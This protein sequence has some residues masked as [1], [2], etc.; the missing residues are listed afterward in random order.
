M[1][2]IILKKIKELKIPLIDIDEEKEKEKGTRTTLNSLKSSV[3]STSSIR[4]VDPVTCL[5][6]NS[7]GSYLLEGTEKGFIYLWDAFHITYKGITMRLLLLLSHFSRV[8][9]CATP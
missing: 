6:I 7:I 3:N 8:R 9:L 2:I 5:D 1:I 4:D